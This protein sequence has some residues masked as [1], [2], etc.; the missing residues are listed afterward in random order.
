MTDS[1]KNEKGRHHPATALHGIF[2]HL[3]LF[4]LLVT[5]LLRL[6]QYVYLIAMKCLLL[7]YA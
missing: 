1:K 6:L 2:V 5:C 4:F 3:I 7:M